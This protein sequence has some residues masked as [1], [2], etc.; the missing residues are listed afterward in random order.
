MSFIRKIRRKG[1]VYY[2]EVENIRVG[3]RI[4]QK[5]IRYI[6]KAPDATNSM[7]IDTV[8]FGYIATLLMQGDLTA[9]ELIEMVEKMGH[10]VYIEDLEA[11]GIRYSFKK[12]HLTLSLFPIR[13]S[14]MRGT[15]QTAG[16]NSRQKRRTK[17]R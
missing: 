15:V 16:Q 17:E 14:R 10:R 5:H 7:A 8:H 2:A 13:Q 12:N 6:G 4:M 9:N 1:C 11:M 3:K